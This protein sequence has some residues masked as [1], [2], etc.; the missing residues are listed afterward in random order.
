M[1]ELI[2]D[3]QKAIDYIENNLADELEITDIAVAAHLSSFHFQR[4]FHVMCGYTVG[5]YIRYR[6]LSLAGEE[7]L[8]T[9]AKV[10]DVALKYGYDSPD[11]FS[12]AFTKFH[13]ATPSVIK[14]GEKR[15]NNLSPLKIKTKSGEKNNMDYRIVEKSAFTV[16]GFGKRFN[17]D[18][19][20]TEIPK[21]WDEHY[22]Y[23]R[24]KMIEGMFG[25]CLDGDGTSFDYII[26]D[27]YLPWKDIPDGCITKTI[28]AGI[29]AV[30]PWSGQCPEALQTVNT[31]IWSE[32]LP[33]SK[34]YTLSCNC[35]LEVY[36]SMEH[37]EIWLPV[38]KI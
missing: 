33:N 23:G 25:V 29:W 26:A 8:S 11:S 14:S 37:G 22:E 30:F 6:R 4:I 35:N 20:Y 15:L 1:S 18:T 17:G 16:V 12:R 5:E 24:D 2:N 34:E 7:L 32:W 13:G 21:F 27:M 10:I 31:R 28:E 38:K 3:I 9:K 36:L 19:A